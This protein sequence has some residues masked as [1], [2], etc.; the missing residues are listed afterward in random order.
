[1]A[2]N[3]RKILASA[4]KHLQKGALDKALKDYQ[5]ALKADPKDSNVR[6]KI[7][8]I[9][10]RQGSRDQAIDAYRKVA[11]RFMDDGFDAKAVAIFKQ[12]SKIDAKRYD[13]FVP[14]SELYQRMGL[15]SEAMGALQTAADGYHREG[16]KHDALDLLR[17]MADL[18]PTNTTSRLKI[19]DVLRQ[20]GLEADAIAEY[21][22]VI[23]E[24]E[25]QENSEG[26]I[27]A[28]ERILELAPKNT[29]ILGKLARTHFESGNAERAE[30]AARRLAEL[31]PDAAEP[32]ELLA[33]I[34]TRL[35]RAEEQE[36]AYRTLAAV[37]RQRGDDDKAREILQ[38]F[39]TSASFQAD[40]GDAGLDFGDLQSADDERVDPL[41]EEPVLELDTPELEEEPSEELLTDDPEQVLAEA[42]V[43][44]RYGKRDKAV[45]SLEA[46]VERH[47]D[48]LGALEKLGEAC[49]AA[50][51]VARASEVWLR[52][53]ELARAA[54]DAAAVAA[55]RDRIAAVDPEA[56]ARLSE[57]GG[58]ESGAA[59]EPTEELVLEDADADDEFVLEIE[60]DDAPAEDD[61]VP[62]E[63]DD[64]PAE[65]AAAAEADAGEASESPA[66]ST[67]ALA[68]DELE[69]D[70][71][72]ELDV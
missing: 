35:G 7:G 36:K 56:A 45:E 70:I 63:D 20:E 67:E 55:L 31:D 52:A 23:A 2:V 29:E 30:P 62:A 21:C 16:R 13:I 15:I 41:L 48:H 1:M 3:K 54:G 8:D 51:N 66:D 57:T 58:A 24:C 19:A 59:P 60:D 50:K 42:S 53:A 26:V 72:V 64:V 38:R 69:L 18:D 68:S 10:L 46:L 4:Q 32:H 65:D 49:A 33:Q 11:E 12:I 6:L 40:S 71:D 28:A 27:A 25:R 22:A 43:Y 5:T 37:Y 34:Y 39:G 14:L 9:L 61:D 44:L 17:K 47:P